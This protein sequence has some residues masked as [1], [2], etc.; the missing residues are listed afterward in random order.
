MLVFHG[1]PQQMLNGSKGGSPL[2][3]QMPSRLTYIQLNGY[4]F[5]GSRRLNFSFDFHSL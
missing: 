2:A 1:K 5:L 4:S 3:H